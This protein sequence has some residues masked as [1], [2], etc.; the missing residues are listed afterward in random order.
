MTLGRILIIMALVS[1]LFISTNSLATTPQINS[2][3][4]KPNE[5]AAQKAQ[6]EF[7][8]MMVREHHF[9]KADLI[10]ELNQT[11]YNP[12]VIKKITHPF[13]HKPW[14]YYRNYFLSKERIDRGIAYWEQHADFLNKVATQY[15][16]EPNIIIAIIGVESLYGTSAGNFSELGTL[17]TLAFYYPSRSRFFTKELKQYLLLTRKYRLPTLKLTGSYA[18]A[19][20]IP[21]FMPSSYQH[22]GVNL[23]NNRSV[24]LFNNHNDAIASIANYLSKEGWQWNKPVALPA[25]IR[26]DSPS[27]IIS[28][29]AT[30]KYT[31]AE[32]NRYGVTPLKSIKTDDKSAVISLTDPG[33]TEYWITFRNFRTIMNYNPS[34]A[35]AM[36]VY[37]LSEAIREAHEYKTA[38]RSTS[39]L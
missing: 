32:L 38:T 17:K 35:Y 22:Y 21:Q 27:K 15:H 39:T 5:T 11:P 23:N 18:G 7:I 19:L 10:R 20:G 4:I 2:D 1:S 24:D 8:E 34:T 26:I 31:L 33:R 3:I 37:Q 25:T 29:R 36:A 28:S 6:A 16:V 30:P 9:N 14:S 12:D 13:E